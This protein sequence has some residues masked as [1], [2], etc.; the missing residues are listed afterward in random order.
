MIFL[1]AR[2]ALVLADIAWL[3]QY[4]GQENVNESHSTAPTH[5][6]ATVSG[7]ASNTVAV[8]VTVALADVPQ[9]P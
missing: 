7:A 4:S 6:N 3:S 2:L 9:Q 1:P 5:L 8:A